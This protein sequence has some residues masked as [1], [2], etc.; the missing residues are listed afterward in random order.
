VQFAPGQPYQATNI[1]RL[2]FTGVEADTTF[3][4]PHD[5]Q[6]QLAY[7]FLHG[8]QAP[9]PG[10]VSRYAFNYPSHQGIFI[11]TGSWREYL[12]A[13]TRVGVTQRFG[14]EAYPVWDLSLARKEGMIRPYIQLANLSNTGYEEI[15][16]VL[17]PSRSVIGGLE[18]V[19]R[20]KKH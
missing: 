7:T 10:T 19:L 5:Q 4:L 13:R 20:Q 17:M 3:R 1:Q 18:F 6:I 9:L 11:W 16:E 2:H 8:D 12:V 14:Q 15:P